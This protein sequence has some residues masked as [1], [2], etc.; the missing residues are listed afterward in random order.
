M[1]VRLFRGIFYTFPLQLILVLL[2]KHMLLLVLWISMFGFVGQFIG[3]HYGIPYLFLDPEYNGQVN[4]YS[5]L[6]IGIAL[7]GFIMSWHMIFYML[8]SF[9][10]HFLASLT[11]PFAVF[12]FNNSVIPGVFLLYYTY[13]IVQF[14]GELNEMIYPDVFIKIAG[15]WIGVLT[16]I[17]LI[18]IYFILLNTNVAR[19]LEKMTDKARQGFIRHDVRLNDL[20]ADMLVDK[21]QWS[22]ESYF[23]SPVK[24]RLA[25]DVSH[26]DPRLVLRVLRQN[27]KNGFVIVFTS[28]LILILLSNTLDMPQFRN[29]AAASLTIFFVLLMVVAGAM[30]Y[31][32][33]GWRLIFIVGALIM[34]NAISTRYDFMYKNKLFGINYETGKLVPYTDEIIDSLAGNDF[35]EQDIYSTTQILKKWRY[36]AVRDYGDKTPPIIFVNVSGGGSKSSYWT[37]HVLQQLHKELGEQFMR[38]TILITGAS[39]GM[40]GSAYFRELYYQHVRGEYIDLTNNIYNFGHG[41]FRFILVGH[42]PAREFG[43]LTQLFSVSQCVQLNDQ[44][45]HFVI[46]SFSFVTKLLDRGESRFKIFTQSVVLI[47]REPQCPKLFL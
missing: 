9:R 34:A 19:F 23:A 22:V 31:W 39:G 12:C 16:V 45:I 3:G 38:H 13:E 40:M 30:S 21:D 24:I 8:N 7:G 20:K 47:D 46:K 6:I 14:R 33:K 36:K 10:F 37:M 1:I 25:R 32:F 41:L 42:C 35:I 11:R 29:P 44:T 43:S 18:T 26:Y 15:L 5:F 2:K 4:F 17:S 28:I 27:H